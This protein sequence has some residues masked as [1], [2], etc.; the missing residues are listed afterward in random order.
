MTR[1]KNNYIYPMN[2]V[3]EVNER[4]SAFH[5]PFAKYKQYSDVKEHRYI[6]VYFELLSKLNALPIHN[7]LL[8]LQ[9]VYVVI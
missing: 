9:V 5:L 7:F 6:C 2:N 1:P 3:L 4:C 8:L